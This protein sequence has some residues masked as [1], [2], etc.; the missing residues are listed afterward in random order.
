MLQIKNI[1]ET[2]DVHSEDFLI[3]ADTYFSTE[4]ED[5]AFEIL[6][7][8]LENGK[9]EFFDEYEV[10]YTDKCYSNE[11]QR[12]AATIRLVH[13]FISKNDYDTV[14]WLYISHRGENFWDWNELN[15]KIYTP[16]IDFILESNDC[17][18]FSS[19]I[20]ANKLHFEYLYLGDIYVTLQN[21]MCKFV[22]DHY[23][24]VN[25]AIREECD[26]SEVYVMLVER[27]FDV[28]AGQV[29]LATVYGNYDAAFLK[30]AFNACKNLFSDS[31]LES[32]FETS[33]GVTTCWLDYGGGITVPDKDVFLN[34]VREVLTKLEEEYF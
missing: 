11:A 22:N 5:E 32:R 31:T 6:R 34:N 7:L 9:R 25:G 20:E 16:I 23:S 29:D 30:D 12:K 33:D 27:V 3:V 28:A 14:I 13:Y 10:F 8:M 21:K 26:L 4:S 18:V 19:F 15:D 24:D 1:I 2:Q 17:E